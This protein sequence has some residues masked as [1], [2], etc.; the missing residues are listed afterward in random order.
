M[1]RL[2]KTM[3]AYMSNEDNGAKSSPFL[4]NRELTAPR[5]CCNGNFFVEIDDLFRGG[6]QPSNGERDE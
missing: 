4:A 6:G 1:S 3:S 5:P 2:E